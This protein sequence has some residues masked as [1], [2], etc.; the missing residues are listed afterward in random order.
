MNLFSDFKVL[1]RIIKAIRKLNPASPDLVYSAGRLAEINANKFGN[2]LAILFEGKSITWKEL[3]QS[4]NRYARALKAEGVKHGDV[5]GIMIENRIEFIIT[6][7]ALSKLGAVASLINTNLQGQSF[8]QCMKITNANRLIFGEELLHVVKEIKDVLA[9]EQYFYIKDVTKKEAPEW[10]LDLDLISEKQSFENLEDTNFVTIKDKIMYIF[11]SGTTGMP[12][13][14]LMTGKRLYPAR[15][16]KDLFGITSND[17]IYL[18]LPLYHSTGLNVGIAL[19]L[20]SGCSIF[21]RRKF[22]ANHF[23]QEARQYNTTIFPYVGELCRYLMHTPEKTNDAQNPFKM[24]IGVGLRPDIWLNF[25]KRFGI[26]YIYE[27]YGAS[28]CPNLLVNIFN[29]DCTIGTTYGGVKLIRYDIESDTIV[30]DEN[31]LCIDVKFGETGLLIFELNNRHVFEGY[32]DPKETDRKIVKD[33]IKRGDEWFNTGD[34]LR[35]IDVGFSFG[36]PHFQFV[37]RV[38]DTFRWKSEN[39]STNEVSEILNQ[40][41][42]VKYS[43]VYGVN[44]PDADGKA[45]MAAIVLKNPQEELN[46]KEFSRFVNKELPPYARP[47]FLRITPELKVTGTFKFMKTSLRSEGYDPEKVKDPLYCL[48]PNKNEYELFKPLP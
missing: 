28:E 43:N 33:V 48:N 24:I 34:L 32:S 10:S 38:G 5:I 4:A 46:I 31:G 39:V 40:F 6:V 11:T 30:R 9:L 26:K 25:K 2:N 37:D 21:M 16:L 12:K 41:M 14:A 47:L 19:A 13:A 1:F 3:N 23:L 45:G 35:Q 15:V 29:R 20:I 44:V 7:L 42:Q 17:R 18:C 27:V 22:S 36:L 8:I